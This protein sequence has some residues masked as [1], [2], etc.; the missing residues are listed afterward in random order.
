M[1]RILDVVERLHDHPFR[2]NVLILGEPGT[3]KD[4][5]AR[6]MG[7]LMAPGKPLVRLDVANFPEEAALAALCGDRKRPGA[8]EQADGGRA[9]DRGGDRPAPARP[10]GAAAAAEGGPRPPGRRGQGRRPAA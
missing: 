4:G 3:G 5:L 9:A 10:G 8:A 6:A 1:G 7:Q 2:T